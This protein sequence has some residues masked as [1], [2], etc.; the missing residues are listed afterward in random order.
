MSEAQPAE[1]L[2]DKSYGGQVVTA[3]EVSHRWCEVSPE[4]EEGCGRKPS[5]CNEET[6]HHDSTTTCTTHHLS[7][8]SKQAGAGALMAQHPAWMI[9]RVGPGQHPRY[10]RANFDQEAV[11]GS[12][13]RPQPRDAVTQTTRL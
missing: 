13:S 9:T 1:D 2:D 5:K 6:I 8:T 10:T 11:G 4:T 7:H 3:S 12:V